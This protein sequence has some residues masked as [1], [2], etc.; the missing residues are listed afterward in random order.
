MDAEPDLPARR[1]VPRGLDSVEGEGDGRH[2]RIAMRLE[3]IG[4]RHER[5]A[6]RLD[7]LQR[8]PVGDP[9]QVER[10]AVEVRHDLLRRMALAVA[11]EIHEVPEHDHDV[12]ET[13]RRD[14]IARAEFAHRLRRQQ[15]VQQLVRPP[16]LAIDLRQMLRLP[17]V[18][19]L[20]LE[21]SADPRPQQDRVE[22]LRQIVLGTQLDTANDAVQLGDRARS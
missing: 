1:V 7:L 17:I 13:P 22:R 19:A 6:D 18:Q 3:E 11:G 9:F 16:P 20:A 21:R 15:R 8:V 10:Q 5:V 12:L 2:H 14:A 4:G